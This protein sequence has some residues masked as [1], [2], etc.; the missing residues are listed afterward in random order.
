[1]SQFEF[2]PS[3]RLCVRKV[4]G[5]VIFVGVLH[6]PSGFRPEEGTGYPLVVAGDQVTALPYALGRLPDGQESGSLGD[7]ASQSIWAEPASA[8]GEKIVLA[9]HCAA[10]ENGWS[11]VGVARSDP[12]APGLDVADP[13]ADGPHYWIDINEGRVCLIHPPV[14][15]SRIKGSALVQLCAQPVWPGPTGELFTLPTLTSR[16]RSLMEVSTKL[17]DMVID[18]TM[19]QEHADKIMRE[20]PGL[21]GLGGSHGDQDYLAFRKAISPYKFQRARD[22]MSAAECARSEG[23]MRL[24]VAAW[25]QE[26]LGSPAVC[27]ALLASASKRAYTD[28][29]AFLEAKA[30]PVVIQGVEMRTRWIMDEG[31]AI[32]AAE[33]RGSGDWGPMGDATRQELQEV[34]AAAGV[35]THAPAAD[36]MVTKVPAVWAILQMEAGRQVA[37]P[38]AE[39]GNSSALSP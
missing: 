14:P 33:Q 26:A 22:P 19:D 2:S 15:Q 13:F 6:Y 5:G 11:A 35:S 25:Q 1:M 8:G 21:Y 38:A 28:L 18:G 9:R 4:S 32:L 16:T 30:W 29:P 10:F 36:T 3:G 37:P 39:L 34:L 27:A 12:F 23:F 20:V 17:G 24:A 7:W 31:G